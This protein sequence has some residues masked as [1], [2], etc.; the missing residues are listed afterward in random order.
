MGIQP[1]SPIIPSSYAAQTSSAYPS[2]ID[3]NAIAGLRHWG[4]AAPRSWPTPTMSLSVD[5]AHLFLGGSNPVE[6]GAWATGTTSS[7]ANSLAN[8][9]NLT[10]IAIGQTCL[11][12]TYN[13][14]GVFTLLTPAGAVVTNVSG[15]T[16]TFSGGNAAASVTGAT[17]IFGQ[18]I[19]TV[20]TGNASGSN[21]LTGL[22][23][24]S[25]IFAGMAVSGTGVSGG[26]TVTSVDS[27][28]QIHVS[29]NVTSGTG[30]SFTFSVPTQ[31]GNPR[32]DRIVINRLTG[33]ALWVMGTAASSPVPPNIPAGYLP[34]CQLAIGTS[35]T[36]ITSTSVISD[37]RDLT[38]FGLG[39]LAYQN[40]ASLTLAVNE[41]QGAT[42]ASASTVAIGAATG[43]FVQISGTTTITAFDTVQAG[44]RRV[45]EFTGALTL[46]Y[47]ATSLILPGAANITTAAG[48]VGEFISLGSGNWLCTNY[49]PASGK[50]VVSGGDNFSNNFYQVREQQ[51]SG[52]AGASVYSSSGAYATVTLN[53]EITSRPSWVTAFSGNTITLAAG[54]Y[55]IRAGVMVPQTG[56]SAKARLRLYNVTSSALVPN[57]LGLSSDMSIPSAGTGDQ[58]A[59][60]LYG[61]FTLSGSTTVRLDAWAQTAG[62]QSPQPCSTG[63][64]EIYADVEIIKVA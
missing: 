41:A 51:P 43:N 15:T 46:T 38:A 27:S 42:I 9:S 25:G 61:R 34:L 23:S 55:D 19:G 40:A 17:V 5:P 30:V 52:T 35:T 16:V 49:Q 10:G 12:F 58:V 62:N 54:T 22:Q 11:A 59:S 26:T 7:S 50:S 44:T 29:A 63:D 45:V 8:V 2:N 32:I 31:T 37:E 33:A 21:V 3:G 24:T 1:T 64:I 39:T 57:M 14:S 53:T 20:V 4:N 60:T 47:N 13:G 56:G 48:D 6:V 36:A 28:S 18:P